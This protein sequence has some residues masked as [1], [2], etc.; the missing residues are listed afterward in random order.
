VPRLFL[1]RTLIRLQLQFSSIEYPKGLHVTDQ[2]THRLRQTLTLSQTQSIH[3]YTDRHGVKMGLKLL[4]TDT[5]H[6]PNPLSPLT[7]KKK[8]KVSPQPHILT[9]N[10]GFSFQPDFKHLIADMKRG[11]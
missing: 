1:L 3:T 7:K 11:G 9:L 10:T 5:Y 6:T 4:V 8:R 2:T